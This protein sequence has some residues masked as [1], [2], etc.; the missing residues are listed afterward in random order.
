MLVAVDGAASTMETNVSLLGC[1]DLTDSAGVEGK[2]VVAAG[3][4][5]IDK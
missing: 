1:G 3:T 4:N 2:G 5:C